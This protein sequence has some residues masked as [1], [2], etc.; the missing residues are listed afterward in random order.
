GLT[1]TLNLT[2]A[3]DTSVGP[4]A[5]AVSKTLTIDGDYLGNN[6]SGIA[7]SGGGALRLFDVQSGGNLTLVHL[8]LTNGLAQGG[9]GGSGPGGGGGGA[10]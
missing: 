4:S 2:L 3:G 9:D 7:L 5:F 8:T 10:A 1:G 6:P